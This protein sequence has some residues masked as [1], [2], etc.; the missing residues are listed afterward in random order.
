MSDV[1]VVVEA[2][3]A[4]DDAQADA[5]PVS[6]E[7]RSGIFGASFN[8]AN[9]IVGAGIIGMP[10]ALKRTG[11]YGGYAVSNVTVRQPVC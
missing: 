8:F 10:F 5:K 11:L 1:K 3:S 9:S 4:S 2:P 7:R 6:D